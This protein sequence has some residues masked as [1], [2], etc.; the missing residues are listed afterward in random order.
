MAGLVGAR[1]DVEVDRSALARIL[2]LPGGLVDRDLRRR[3]ERVAARARATAP[4]GMRDAISVEL[5]GTGRGRRARVVLNHPAALYVTQG[6]GIYGRRGSSYPIRPRFARA[7]RFVVG[8]RVVYA[9]QVT[10]PGIKPNDFL[11][12]ALQSAR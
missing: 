5:D 7:L 4:G 10:H 6:T 8:G 11:N 2:R 12:K 3:A 9:K 1:V